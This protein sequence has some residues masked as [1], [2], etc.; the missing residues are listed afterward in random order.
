M[1]ALFLFIFYMSYVSVFIFLFLYTAFSGVKYMFFTYHLNYLVGTSMFL[2]Y[3]YY[4]LVITLGIKMSIL[5][6][7]SYE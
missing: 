4:Y 3:H 5:R 7:S 6:Q 1:C 2:S